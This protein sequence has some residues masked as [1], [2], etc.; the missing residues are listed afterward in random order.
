MLDFRL[1]FNP[2][3]ANKHLMLYYQNPLVLESR[4]YYFAIPLADPVVLLQGQKATRMARLYPP[5]VFENK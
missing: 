5:V 2:I 1:R 3:D 4:M